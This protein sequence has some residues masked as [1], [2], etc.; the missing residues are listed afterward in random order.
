M[1]GALQSQQPAHRLGRCAATSRPSTR[2][3][4]CACSCRRATRRRATRAW[5]RWAGGCRRCRASRRR[6]RSESSP[7][8]A[9]CGRGGARGGRDQSRH[10]RQQTSCACRPR[11]RCSSSSCGSP[12]AAVA[13]DA[14][15]A[16]C[17]CAQRCALCCALACLQGDL[18]CPPL[19]WEPYLATF[20]AV[21]ADAQGRGGRPHGA[22]G[23]MCCSS[24]RLS[25]G[26]APDACSHA[27]SPA[28]LPIALV[29]LCCCSCLLLSTAR[30]WTRRSAAQQQPQRRRAAGRTALLPAPATAAATA[31]AVMTSLC[32]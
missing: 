17:S 13:L 22:A 8:S 30:C 29:L 27:H 24:R 3:A 7:A 6:R 28:Y 15:P 9:R 14:R 26:T 10:T 21:S 2:P 18:E 12:A 20:K 25:A 1:Q 4:C 31:G 5:A 16:A 11:R 23:R 19:P 32:L